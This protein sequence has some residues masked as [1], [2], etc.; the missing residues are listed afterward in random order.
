V[1]PVV[2]GFILN[3]VGYQIP[4]F[5]ACGAAII[6]VLVTLRLNPAAQRSPARVALDEARAAAQ[7]ATAGTLAYEAAAGVPPGITIGFA[8]ASDDAGDE[9]GRQAARAQAES[10]EEQ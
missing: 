8:T 2:A 1:V 4:F 3:Y 10:A 7:A 5:I 9:P 6:T